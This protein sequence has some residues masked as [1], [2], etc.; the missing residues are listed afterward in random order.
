[1]RRRGRLDCRIFRY[2]TSSAPSHCGLG[3]TRLQRKEA[4]SRPK[5]KFS[6]PAQTARAEVRRHPA[7]FSNCVMVVT[8]FPKQQEY[9]KGVDGGKGWLMKLTSPRYAE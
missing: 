7:T 2:E 5:G 6:T 1:M 9:C 8:V 3:Q 4:G